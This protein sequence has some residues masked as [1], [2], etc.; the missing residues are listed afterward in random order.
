M[1]HRRSLVRSA[2]AGGSLA[3]A[4]AASTAQAIT[5]TIDKNG[6]ADRF[7]GQVTGPGIAGTIPIGNDGS[8]AVLAG[9]LPNSVYSVDFFHNSGAGG[10][11]FIFQ[12]GATGVDSVGLGGGLFNMVTGFNPGDTTLILNTLSVTYNA[13]SG[14]TGVYYLAGIFDPYS[15]GQNTGPLTDLKIIPGWVAVDNLYNTGGNNEDYL[16]YVNDDGTVSAYPGYEEYATFSGNAVSPRA[17]D[18]QYTVQSSGALPVLGIPYIYP[19]TNFSSSFNGADPLPYTYTFTMK[20]TIGNAGLLMADFGAYQVVAASD[21]IKPDGSS[22][23][24]LAGGNDWYFTPRLRYDSGDGFFKWADVGNVLG[25]YTA[26]GEATGF[27][28]GGTSPLTVRVTALLPEP[29][30]PPTGD[31]VPEPASLGVAAM[32]AGVAALF[33]RRRRD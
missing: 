13:N 5:I 28:D 17:V 10:S 26:S 4:L 16:F 8:N 32:L 22:Q 25:G 30:P 20:Q 14:Q 21:L 18:V 9:L 12:T 24:G 2:L 33:T 29:P 19:L 3:F 1:P 7:N 6:F 15:K 11:D 27:Y 31:A 23:L